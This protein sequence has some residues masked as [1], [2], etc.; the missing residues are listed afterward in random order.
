MILQT[1]NGITLV[2][3]PDGIDLGRWDFRRNHGTL[4]DGRLYHCHKVW[5][6]QVKRLWKGH[7]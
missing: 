6:T 7:R 1:G 3:T 5:F 2:Q 4:N